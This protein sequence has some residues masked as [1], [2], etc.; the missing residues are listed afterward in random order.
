M[1]IRCKF[2]IMAKWRSFHCPSLFSDFNGYSMPRR[3]FMSAALEKEVALTTNSCDCK[4]GGKNLMSVAD[5]SFGK[6]QIVP[7]SQ[8]RI[9]NK[10][11]QQVLPG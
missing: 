4:L 1:Q 7:Y 3:H 2:C 8:S 9:H 11:Y 5:M 6:I 10:Y